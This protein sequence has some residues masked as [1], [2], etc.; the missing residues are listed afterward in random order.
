MCLMPRSQKL[1]APVLEPPSLTSG[2]RLQRTSFAAKPHGLTESSPITHSA[3]GIQTRLGKHRDMRQP[4]R[5]SPD[6]PRE[7]QSRF[8]GASESE[9]RVPEQ[10]AARTVTVPQP[11]IW[12][13]TPVRSDLAPEPPVSRPGSR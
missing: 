9:D 1:L 5:P 6:N 8:A 2:P 13:G 4:W 11:W 3:R 10:L 7:R 12:N